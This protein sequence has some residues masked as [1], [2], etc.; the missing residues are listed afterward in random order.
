MSNNPILTIGYST[1]S[2]RISNIQ[3][4]ELQIE[5]KVFISIQDP[6]GR[7]FDLPK[8]YKFE[9]VSAQT[10][11]VAKSRNVVLESTSSKYLLFADDEIQFAPKSIEAAVAFLESNP[12]ID[13]V[14]A[15]TV[16][17]N[18]D[19]RKKYPLKQTKL[20]LFNSAKAATYEMLVRVDSIKAKGIRF[21]ESFG[22]GVDNY[23][24]DE[25]IFISDLL[26]AKGSA[27][28]LPLT[29]AIHPVE[30]SGS[31]WGSAKNLRVRAAIFTR[32]FG[33]WAPL[34]RLAFYFKSYKKTP[35]LR[36]LITFVRG[37]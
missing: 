34:V 20:N 9:Y 25:Y 21:D 4:P 17:T 35:G 18:G 8:S 26:K 11:G 12:S 37:K 3:P 31:G 14:L 13:L 28:F 1:L 29:I 5:S 24:G 10:K 2:E 36:S 22:A 23:L 16:D 32:V 27:V 15:Q 30:S 7:G 33:P 6:A 19:L